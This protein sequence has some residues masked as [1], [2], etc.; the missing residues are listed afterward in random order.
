MTTASPVSSP[1]QKRTAIRHITSLYR[2]LSFGLAVA[3]WASAAP[4][5]LAQSHPTPGTLVHFPSVPGPHEQLLTL[6]GW[7]TL[8]AL[9]QG[10]GGAPGIVMMHG[11]GGPKT[12]SYRWAAQ[13]AEWGYASLVLDSFGPRKLTEICSDHSLLGAPQRTGDAYGALQYLQGRQG[14]DPDRIGLMGWSHGGSS[15]LWAIDPE[16]GRKHRPYP[17]ARF[18]ATAVFYPGCNEAQNVFTTPLIMLMGT[19]DD[20]TPASPCRRLV[21]TART[22]DGPVQLVIYK[23]ATH[24]FDAVRTTVEAYGHTLEYSP[25]ATADAQARVHAFLDE[26]LKR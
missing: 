10:R 23:G 14:I 19:A 18:R 16:W 20:W 22:P 3:I 6:R 4:L 9:P 24:A 1:V 21:K 12:P 8:P 11:C 7:F 25:E 26:H 15:A 17:W 5:A 13:L 2:G